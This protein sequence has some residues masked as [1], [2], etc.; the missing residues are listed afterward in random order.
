MKELIEILIL[1]IYEIMPE[2]LRSNKMIVELVEGIAEK[3]LFE[4]K[5]EVIKLNWEKSFLEKDLRQ[6][7][8]DND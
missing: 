7:K 3:R 2:T 1:K 6:F 4:V 5:Q 8:G